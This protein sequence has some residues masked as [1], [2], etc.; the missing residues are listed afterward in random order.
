MPIRMASVA[1]GH[2]L[3]LLLY[4][5]LVLSQKMGRHVKIAQTARLSRYRQGV[6]RAAHRGSYLVSRRQARHFRLSPA[7]MSIP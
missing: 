3:A 2:E 1:L 5:K 4:Q 7:K 6:K